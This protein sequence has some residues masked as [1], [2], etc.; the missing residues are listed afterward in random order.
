[1]EITL[2]LEKMTAAEK[3]RLMESLWA[4]L[5]RHEEELESPSWHGQVLRETEQ[6]VA[7]GEEKA[8]DWGVAKKELRRLGG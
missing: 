4:D 5:S 7:A 8:V 3:I 2:P 6:R 1:M